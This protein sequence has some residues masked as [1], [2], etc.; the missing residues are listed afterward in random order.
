[1]LPPKY[2]T[3][4]RIWTMRDPRIFDHSDW[5][6]KAGLHVLKCPVFAENIGIVRS[7]EGSIITIP[8]IPITITHP[9]NRFSIATISPCNRHDYDYDYIASP[10]LKND[11]VTA[12][13]KSKLI[14]K[15][16]NTLM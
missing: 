1:M 4:G 2:A 14:K 5:K 12:F 15:R 9:C 10:K 16:K 6:S 8:R 13:I 3:E 11:F 7:T